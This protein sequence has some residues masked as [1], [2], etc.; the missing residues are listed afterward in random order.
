MNDDDRDLEHLLRWPLPN[1][2]DAGFSAAVMQRVQALP[3]MLAAEQALDHLRR[4]QVRDA[5]CR[6]LV[7]YASALGAALALAWLAAAG[8]NTE[9]ARENIEAGDAHQHDQ[10]PAGGKGDLFQQVLDGVGYVDQSD[11]GSPSFRAPGAGFGRCPDAR[12]EIL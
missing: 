3:P 9:L 10:Q 8:G 12:V 6:H 7:S 4:Q 2:P 1:L 11:H 5:R